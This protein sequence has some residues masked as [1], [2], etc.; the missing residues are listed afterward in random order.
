MEVDLFVKQEE[1]RG[2]L[3]PLALKSFK[4]GIILQILKWVISLVY[5]TGPL[6]IRAS[7]PV[8]SILVIGLFLL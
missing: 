8:V 6:L 7:L 1:L 3:H 4:P 2:L 5:A